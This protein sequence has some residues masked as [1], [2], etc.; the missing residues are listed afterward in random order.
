M[1]TVMKTKKVR[2]IKRPGIYYPNQTWY[3]VEVKRWWW[4]ERFE[5]YNNY[6]DA[7]NIANFLERGQGPKRLVVYDSEG[8]GRENT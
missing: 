1:E 3:D 4:W 2:I 8:G 7:L 6:Q 5:M